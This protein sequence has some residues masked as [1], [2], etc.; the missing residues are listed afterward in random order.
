MTEKDNS[1]P[2]TAAELGIGQ[3]SGLPPER[4]ADS[5][6]WTL[7]PYNR[8]TFQRVQQF[9]RTTR[10]PRAK[11]P[12]ALEEDFQDLTGITFQD[13]CGQQCTV[14]E[15][16]TRTYA[17]GLLVLHQ[18]KVLTEQYF[19]GMNRATLH[20]IM[21]CSKSVTSAVVGAY[22]EAGVLD[23]SAQLTD[24]L[25]EL[26]DSGMAD[27]TLQQAL[28][29]QVGVKFSEDYDDLDAEW[30]QC[31]LAT[32]WRESPDYD[33]PRDQLSYA[34]TLTEQEAEHGTVFH[35]QSILTNVIGCCL[36]RASGKLFAELVAEHIWMPMGAEQD[37]V[38][39]IDAAGIMSFEGGFNICLRDFAR[40][41]FL[42]SQDGCYQGQQLVPESWL[43]ECR[44]P[45]DKLIESFAA[46]EYAEVLPGGAYH[47]QW[48]VRNPEKGIIMALGIHGQTLYIDCERKFVAAKFSSQPEQANIAM[49]MDQMLAFEA[50]VDTV[51]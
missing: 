6:N 47:N 49:A 27:A 2:K 29:M 40:F 15:M 24:Y 23:P 18:G 37:L 51:D 39:I 41:G 7:A 26:A 8:W 33:G 11:S 50:I 17:D 4:R 13:L 46:S 42:I 9:A 35:Y 36:E 20:L 34:Q 30:R 16:L 28:D 12:S 10:V 3:G 43:R 38:S 14:G 5:Q 21:S 19:N 32:G 1:A 25:P 22:I 44:N 48:W 31:E 45:N